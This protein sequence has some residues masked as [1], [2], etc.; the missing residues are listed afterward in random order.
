[1]AGLDKGISRSRGSGS[2]TEPLFLNFEGKGF[3]AKAI[4]FGLRKLF[5]KIIELK[6]IQMIGPRGGQG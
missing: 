3:A 6:L 2:M 5:G 1:M 4:G